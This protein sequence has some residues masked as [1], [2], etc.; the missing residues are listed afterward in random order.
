MSWLA[1]LKAVEA[2]RRANLQNLQKAAF[3][4]FAGADPAP[5]QE[6][7]CHDTIFMART[8][9]FM[10]RDLD[11]DNADAAANRLAQRDRQ[12]DERRIC[13]ECRHLSGSRS[14]RYCRQGKETGQSGSSIIPS[15]LAAT[16]Q[17]CAGFEP[18]V[19]E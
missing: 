14:R 13:L 5:F 3:V 17:R 6:R 8:A 10:S 15:E 16:L 4:G 9:L 19:L 7:E 18:E 12:H 2:A 1:R 11:K